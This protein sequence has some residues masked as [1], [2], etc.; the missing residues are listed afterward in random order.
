MDLKQLL[1]T[2]LLLAL[3]VIIAAH[4]ASGIGYDST[5][6]LV[7]AVLLLSF[8]N[9]VLKPVLMLFSLPFI[10]LT[11]GVGIWLINALLFM[12]VGA[13]VEG[14]HVMSFWNALWGALV[15][16]LT[17]VAANLLF[18]SSRIDVQSSQGQSTHGTASQRRKPLKDDDDVIDI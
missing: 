4:T 8:C 15:V 18:G 5:A 1:K 12:L 6:A 17:G 2:W 16:S 13:L 10:I 14:F 9:L 11:F 3:G 7:V